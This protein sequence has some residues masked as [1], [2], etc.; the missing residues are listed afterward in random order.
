MLGTTVIPPP[1]EMFGPDT[2]GDEFSILLFE[3]LKTKK[4]LDY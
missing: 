2:L 3:D 1:S 4:S